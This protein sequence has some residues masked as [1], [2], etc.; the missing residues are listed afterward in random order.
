ML[1]DEGI[2]LIKFWLDVDRAE[3]LQRFLDREKDP[4]KQWKLSQI[5]IDGLSKWDDYT[6]AIDETLEKSHFKNA[7]WTVILADDKYRTRIA[8][9]QKI[10]SSVDYIGKEDRI[11]GKM[12][13]KIIGGPKIR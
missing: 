5:D 2:I 7:P 6:K 12:D 1:V 8:V 4:L 10:L 3:Q 9:M 13:E 11:I